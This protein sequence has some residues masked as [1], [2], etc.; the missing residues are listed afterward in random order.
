MSYEEVEYTF[1]YV[2][3]ENSDDVEQEVIDY[4]TKLKLADK[5]L[6]QFFG[7]SGVVLSGMKE[8]KEKILEGFPGEKFFCTI[9]LGYCAEAAK[10]TKKRKYNDHRRFNDISTPSA[11]AVAN[12]ANEDSW[13]QTQQ[14]KRMEIFCLRPA[15]KA[16]IN[17]S[18]VHNVFAQV[19]DVLEKGTPQTED[20]RLRAE[21]VAT[22][23]NGFSVENKRRDD[24]NLI[25]E[26]Y[27]SIPLELSIGVRGVSGTKDTD[28]SS[29]Q[30]YIF[31]NVNIRLWSR[32]YF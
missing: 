28:G 3:M 30:S 23:P 5:K 27:I 14:N 25:L 26:R 16:F 12:D 15:G 11:F 31:F 24:V 9:F 13:M 29:G 6:S 1:K 32:T 17:V 18:L 8:T 22:M 10:G 7:K 20:W 19:T 4:F 2:W 21:L